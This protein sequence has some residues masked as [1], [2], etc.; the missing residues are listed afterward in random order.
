M[1]PSEDS[2]E[3]EE[4]SGSPITISNSKKFLSGVG[5]W[6]RNEVQQRYTDLLAKS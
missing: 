6:D 2:S 4:F 5:A 3:T 1:C